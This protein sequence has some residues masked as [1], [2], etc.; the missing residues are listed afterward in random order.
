MTQDQITLV[1]NSWKLLQELEPVIIGDAFYSKLFLDAPQVRSMFKSSRI[2]QANK[3]IATLAVVVS[4]LEEI[5]KLTHAIQQL[6]I[7][8]VH[9]GVEPEHYKLVG[10]VMIW[11]LEK[12]LEDNWNDELKEAWDS[13]YTILS[14]TMINGAYSKAL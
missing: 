4:R 8:H 6:A 3:L 2:E 14:R 13:C 7:R 1:K 10:D 9:Y 12:L 5:E 11:T